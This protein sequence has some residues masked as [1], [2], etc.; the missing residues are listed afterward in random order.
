MTQGYERMLFYHLF[1]LFDILKK[2]YNLNFLS[3]WN[4]KQLNKDFFFKLKAQFDLLLLLTLILAR[5]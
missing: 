3:K 4:L 1:T 5:Q 2:R